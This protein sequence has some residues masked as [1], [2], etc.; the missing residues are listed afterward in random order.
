[1]LWFNQKKSSFLKVSIVPK[2]LKNIEVDYISLVNKGANRKEV[3]YKSAEGKEDAPSKEVEVKKYDEELGIMYGVVYSPDE[4]DTQGD[5]ASA[6]EIRKAAYQYMKKSSA[7]KVD[8]EHNT[9]PQAAFVAES[10]I[11]QKNDSTFPNEK[12][13]SWAVGIKLESE[14][15][16]K[17]VKAG[18]LKAFSIGGRAERTEVTKSEGGEKTLSTFMKSF[19][20]GLEKLVKNKDGQSP[21]PLGIS[22]T[23][24]LSK[25]VEQGFGSL[26]SVIEKQDARIQQ[27]EKSLGEQGA[28]LKKS[29]QMEDFKKSDETSNTPNIL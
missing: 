18:E 19:L 4:V 5:Q 15:L 1:M 22:S 16:K 25:A 8:L 23:D 3:I 11:L 24:E 17:A 29:R 28:L 13:G 6:S 20:G 27:L 12:E 26:Q 10:W 14:E 21:A 7:G 9:Q 2:E